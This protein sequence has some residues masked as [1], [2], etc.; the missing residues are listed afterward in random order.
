M[1]YR[2]RKIISFFLFFSFIGGTS[3]FLNAGQAVKT[4][5]QEKKINFWADRGEYWGKE[6]KLKLYNNVKVTQEKAEL[7]AKEVT[8]DLEKKRL[9]INEETHFYDQEKE[10][11]AQGL[12]YN[13]DIGKAVFRDSKLIFKPWYLQAKELEKIE[14]K[15]YLSRNSALTTC[16][17]SSPHYHF[18]ARKLNLILNDELYAQDIFF[19]VGKLPIFYLPFYYHSLKEKKLSIQIHPGYSE[20]EGIYFRNKIGYPL[21]KNTY[22]KFYLDYFQKKG[23]GTGIEYNYHPSERLRGSL[24][25]YHIKEKDTLRERWNIRYFHWSSI[26]RDLTL[27][28]NANF[29]S[30]EYFSRDWFREDWQRRILDTY[31][32]NFNYARA[33]FTSRLLIEKKGSYFRGAQNL[34]SS[35]EEFFVPRFIFFT[36]PIKLVSFPAFYNLSFD[37]ANYYERSPNSPD[38]YRF[39]GEGKINLTNSFPLSRLF[40]FTPMIGFKTSNWGELDDVFYSFYLT[41]LNLRF[42]P[43]YWLFFDFGHRYTQEILKEIKENAFTFFGEYCPSLN[44]SLKFSTGYDFLKKEKI[45]LV[46]WLTYRPLPY[47]LIYLYNTYSLEKQEILSWQTEFTLGDLEKKYLLVGLTYS[48]EPEKYFLRSGF[49]LSLTKSW[50]IEFKLYTDLFGSDKYTEKEI[51]LTRDLHCWVANFF[52]RERPQVKEWWFFLSLKIS[53]EAQKKLYPREQEQE[54]YPWR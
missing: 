18:Q 34:I 10:I 1:V 11:F 33:N 13:F 49:A 42:R 38:F 20:T 47:F 46:N 2:Q 41:N 5:P 31:T 19:Y 36:Q 39:K 12:E 3:S 44:L 43:Q 17:L 45:D 37:V 26:T 28:A 7:S 16:E 40:I 4:L 51:S 22:G 9:F 6:D 54:W 52:Y 27:N 35:K 32:L 30:D 23:W 48:S 8:I 24:Y 25:G 53:Y 50:Q 15:K 21:T 29:L 14:E